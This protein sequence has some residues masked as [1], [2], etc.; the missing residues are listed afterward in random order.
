M[1]VVLVPAHWRI[2]MTGQV[3]WSEQTKVVQRNMAEM[4]DQMSLNEPMEVVVPQSSQV[5]HLMLDEQMEAGLARYEL[6]NKH[7]NSKVVAEITIP[8][9]TQTTSK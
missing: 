1:K 8:L 3:R 7:E 6:T 4:V 2:E 5:G 9:T